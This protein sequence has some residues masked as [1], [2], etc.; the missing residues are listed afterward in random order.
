MPPAQ[1]GANMRERMATQSFERSVASPASARETFEGT[2][3]PGVVGCSHRGTAP[4]SS[5]AAARRSASRRARPISAWAWG[6]WESER[7]GC[8]SAPS[9]STAVRALQE[10]EPPPRGERRWR[11][12]L[13]LADRIAPCPRSPAVDR[14]RSGPI[15]APEDVRLVPGDGPRPARSRARRGEG[16][17][18]RRIAI[19]ASGLIGRTLAAFLRTGGHEVLEL[20]RRALRAAHEVRWDPAAGTVDVAVEGVDDR[21]PRPRASSGCAGPPR[22]SAASRTAAWGTRAIVAAINAMERLPEGRRP[23]RSGCTG[24]VQEVSRSPPRQ[25]WLPRGDVPGVEAGV[26]ALRDDVRGALA[27]AWCR[28]RGLTRCSPP[29]AGA[30]GRLGAGA[31]VPLDR[32]DDAVG[33]F[34]AALHDARLGPVNPVAPGEATNATF[35]RALGRRCDRP[36]CRRPPSRCP[37]AGRRAGG[38]CSS[39]ACA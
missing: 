6:R 16:F 10:L 33:A 17:T 18:G 2:C 39:R 24:T 5:R 14:W 32:V 30:G 35:T 19:G 37:R 20:V 29:Q 13:D 12:D 23:P 22:R 1:R 3:A 28:R 11:L 21:P 4:A 25:G 9:S 38:R 8:P 31:V 26:A 36:S 27:L 7:R 34:H 15:E